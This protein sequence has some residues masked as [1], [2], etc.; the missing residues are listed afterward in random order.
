MCVHVLLQVGVCVCR[1][2][3]TL[4]LLFIYCVCVCTCRSEDSLRTSVGSG[5]LT[6]AVGLAASTFPHSALSPASQPCFFET[7]FL[8]NSGLTLLARLADQC[9]LADPPVS[10]PLPSPPHP[11][12][13]GT[14]VMGTCHSLGVY[15]AVG[16]KLRLMLNQQM[17]YPPRHRISTLLFKNRESCLQ[18]VFHN[19][20]QH[21]PLTGLWVSCS[22][23]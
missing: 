13:P 21:W 12:T 14:G 9:E 22:L 2:E 8:I 3:M 1:P 6:Q 16:F 4:I 23:K 18:E 19:Q 5:D 17:L 11:P 20:F 10:A 15:M 7:V